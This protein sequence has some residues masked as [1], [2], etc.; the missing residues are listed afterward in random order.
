MTASRSRSSRH[1]T[2]RE[3]TTATATYPSSILAPI[4]AALAGAIVFHRALAVYFSQDDFL[5]LARAGGLAPRLA[6]PWRW[7]SHQAFFD[8]M[9]AV[10]GHDPM[11]YHWVALAAHAIAAVLLWRWLARRTTPAAAT[12]GAVFFATHAAAFTALYWISAVGDVLALLFALASLLL[13]ARRDAWRWLAL[14]AFALS[15]ASKESTLFLPL[16]A[17]A[18]APS[19]SPRGRRDPLLAGLALVALLGAASF[20]LGNAFGVRESGANVPYAIGWG[21]H[22]WRNALT[23]LG[24]TANIPLP[25]VQGFSDFVDPSV[26]GWGIGALVVWLAGLFVPAL[27]ARGWAPAG[28]MWLAFLLPV[29]ALRNHVNHYYLYASLAGAAWCVAAALDAAFAWQSERHQRGA[30]TPIEW[31]AAGT[32]AVLLTLNGY[33]LVAKIETM[34]FVLHE[35]RADPTVDR[36]RIA[37]NVIE[38]LEYA[39]LP[40]GTTLRFWSPSASSIGARGEP[41]GGTAPQPTYWETNVRQA[42]LDGLAVR[43]MVPAVAAVSFVREYTPAPE[44]ERYVVYR[45]DG[46]VRI[47]TSAEVDSILRRLAP[48]DSTRTR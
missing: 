31:I 48:P 33:L 1:P 23:Y 27:R 39:E 43:V 38:S 2:A 15:L 3:E 35:L 13:V 11:P 8:V 42:L 6:G 14:P 25:T 37:K 41:L 21:A 29:I 18:V 30:S 17:W 44:G 12:A 28:A 34:P 26:F 40:R 24:W 32:L 19:L 47:A 4:A 46:R 16:V 9:R 45:P 7:L 20:V 10:A 22:L 5:G 36:A